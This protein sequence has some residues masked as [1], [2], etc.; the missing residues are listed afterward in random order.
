M[1]LSGG[2]I[3]SALVITVAD[4]SHEVAKSLGR[5]ESDGVRLRL[6]RQFLM[7]AARGDVKSLTVDPPPSTGS[8]QWDAFLAGLAEFVAHRGNVPVPQWTSTAD[9]FLSTWWFLMPFK[10]LHGIALAE[11]PAAFANRG[12]FISRAGLVNL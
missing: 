10:S 1:E 11:T 7:D 3:Y 8:A 4:L 5:F 9:K 12:V 2:G 6:V